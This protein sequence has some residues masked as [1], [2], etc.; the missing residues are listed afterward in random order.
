MALVKNIDDEDYECVVIVA[1][2]GAASLFSCS[3]CRNILI[4]Y[5]SF[6]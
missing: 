3:K 1:A 4:I 2:G 6:S 5:P